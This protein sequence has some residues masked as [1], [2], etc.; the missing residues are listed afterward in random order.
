MFPRQG[1]PINFTRQ[2]QWWVFKGP[3][4]KG[5]SMLIYDNPMVHNWEENCFN[6]SLSTA[7]W[8][9]AS[10]FVQQVC[11]SLSTFFYIKKIWNTLI[12]NFSCQDILFLLYPQQELQA[13]W[14]NHIILHNILIYEKHV[15]FLYPLHTNLGI[16]TVFTTTTTSSNILNDIFPSLLKCAASMKFKKRTFL[17][18][19]VNS[20]TWTLDRS[21]YA[22]SFLPH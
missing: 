13:D 5:G 3:R 12:V 16:I 9:A 21:Y 14:R 22:C 7:Q 10:V 18:K 19:S 2:T 4:R 6:N 11:N 8:A 15:F 17:Q 20:I 1:N